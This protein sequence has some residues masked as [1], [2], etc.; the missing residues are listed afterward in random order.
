MATDIVNNKGNIEKLKKLFETIKHSTLQNEIEQQSD[1]SSI[2][3]A[4]YI[5]E[6]LDDECTN[7]KVTAA[8][9]VIMKK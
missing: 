6:L 2:K 8:L 3:A 5:L 4:L 7:P 1:R 9:E